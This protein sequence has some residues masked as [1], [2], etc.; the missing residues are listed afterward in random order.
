MTE[1]KKSNRGR[2]TI[3]TPELGKSICDMISAVAT[4]KEASHANGLNES[5][6][7]EW[8]QK[9]TADPESVYGKFAESV[10]HARSRRTMSLKAQIR[11][12][13]KK[14]W[15]A[16]AALGAI[17][18]PAEFVPQIRIHISNEY[19][20]AIAR[21]REEFRDAPDIYERALQAMVGRSTQER[22]GDGSLDEGRED[23]DGGEALHSAQPEPE[24]ESI[25]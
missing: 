2:K 22:I 8:I 24:A 23:A 15:R 9:G 1:K 3:L 21:L 16:L 12:H 25:P 5:T 14:D 4:I 7:H 18:D 11:S 10:R 17:T 6:V 20:Q 13:G 19:D